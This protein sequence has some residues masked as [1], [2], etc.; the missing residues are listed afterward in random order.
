MRKYGSEIQSEC[1][2]LL[3]KERW[4]DVIDAT[5]V[6]GLAFAHVAELDN[7]VVM[8]LCHSAAEYD[9]R[10][11]SLSGRYPCRLLLLVKSRPDV[12]CEIRRSIC[13]ELLEHDPEQLEPSTLKITI[14]L[15]KQLQDG[16]STGM[17]HQKIF[18]TVH[19]LARHWRGC[20]QDI[21]GV[22]N[23]LKS[24]INRAPAIS[25][26]LASARL[27]IGK[28][29]SMMSPNGASS[30]KWSDVKDVVATVVDE[31]VR[32]FD[33]AE[34]IIEEETRWGAPIPADVQML[35]PPL[36]A[37]STK[38]SDPKFVWACLMHK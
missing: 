6:D 2:D 26:Q 32:H 24:L 15:A 19:G 1:S 36:L 22:N 16:K 21:E 20:T 5:A 23:M 18:D 35:P 37:P 10:F 13:T 9:I 3:N 11:G 17:L 4:S 27:A 34:D 7:V 8:M 12:K 25:L 38:P 30:P 33:R 14:I 31:C 28:S 29:L